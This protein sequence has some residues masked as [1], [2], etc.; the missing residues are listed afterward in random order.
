MKRQVLRIDRC[1]D[2]LMWY[3]EHVGYL[4][5]YRGPDGPN[6]YLSRE[7]AGYTN[8][9]RRTDATLLELDDATIKEQKNICTF[10]H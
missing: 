7:D 4:V 6:F 3:R 10:R 2:R 8:I 1:P 5:D 9:V